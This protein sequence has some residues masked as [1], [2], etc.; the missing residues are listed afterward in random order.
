MTMKV[1]R[2]RKCQ[3]F[4]MYVHVFTFLFKNDMLLNSVRVCSVNSLI[5]VVT[6]VFLMCLT[7]SFQNH[8]IEHMWAEINSRVNYPIKRMPDHVTGQEKLTWTALT[9]NSVHHGFPFVSATLKLL[10]LFKLGTNVQ[11]QEQ[12]TSNQ[13]STQE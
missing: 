3:I 10:W 4:L 7:F 5:R 13:C 12:F 6:N 1:L 2:Q 8:S 11:Y 9:R